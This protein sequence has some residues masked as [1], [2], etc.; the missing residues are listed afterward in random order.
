MFLTIIA[1][2]YITLFGSS[3]ITFKKKQLS[4]IL[5]ITLIF[6]NIFLCWR[7]STH[8]LISVCYFNV[9]IG[10]Q[11]PKGLQQLEFELGFLCHQF[12]GLLNSLTRSSIILDLSV[13]S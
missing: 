2:I 5:T 12:L 11:E 8:S 4:R 3:R 9:N 7:F 1:M 10:P 6:A 13:S